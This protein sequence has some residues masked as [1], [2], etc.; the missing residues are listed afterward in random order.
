M[1]TSDYGRS[2]FHKGSEPSIFDLVDTIVV[3]QKYI[4]MANRIRTEPQFKEQKK[5]ELIDRLSARMNRRVFNNMERKRSSRYNKHAEN[6]KEMITYLRNKN[7]LGFNGVGVDELFV[8]ANNLKQAIRIVYDVNV[9]RAIK[10]KVEVLLNEG[11]MRK[12]SLSKDIKGYQFII[13]V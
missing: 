7:K 3:E 10:P 13:S 9:I 5:K 4:D 11:L 2:N 8:T 1:A 12:V 6:V